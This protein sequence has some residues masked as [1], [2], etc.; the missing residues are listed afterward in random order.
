MYFTSLIGLTRTW[1][2]SVISS[3]I[4]ALSG[5]NINNSR[6]RNAFFVDF[7]KSGSTPSTANQLWTC[8]LFHPSITYPPVDI[9]YSNFYNQMSAESPSYSNIENDIAYFPMSESING[10][11]NTVN[12][13]WNKT[14]PELEISDVAVWRF[15]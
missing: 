7:I 13:Y 6:N 11:M 14:A 5:S 3:N 12:I 10:V 15:S 9:S 1:I 8:S 4:G 2:G